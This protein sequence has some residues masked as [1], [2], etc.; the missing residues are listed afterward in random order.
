MELR[1][2]ERLPGY[3]IDHCGRVFSHI[4]RAGPFP[5]KIDQLYKRQIR[6]ALCGKK[7]LGF[8]FWL[9]GK[10]RTI[11]VHRFLCEAF[12]GPPPSPKSWVR[13]LNDDPLDNRVENLC[14]GTPAENARDARRNGKMG[15]GFMTSSHVF[16]TRTEL[17]IIFSLRAEG[18]SYQAI[19]TQFGCS[20]YAVRQL[21]AGVTYAGELPVLN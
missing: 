14:W 20:Y 6:T 15:T 11:L 12:H 8:N 5:G 2:I 7:Y 18:L 1:Q 10:P 3:S 21:L 13:H 19:A 4:K 17:M 16:K 9:N